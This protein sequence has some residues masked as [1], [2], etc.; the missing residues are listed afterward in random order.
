[1]HPKVKIGCRYQKQHYTM[2]TPTNYEALRPEMSRDDLH[3]QRGLLDERKAAA[4]WLLAY[5]A[6]AAAVGLWL[7]FPF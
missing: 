4:R 7:I 2:R 1:M 3:L 6:T 5:F